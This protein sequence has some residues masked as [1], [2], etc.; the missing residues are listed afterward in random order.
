M[1]SLN[2]KHRRRLKMGQMAARW[3]S[4]CDAGR[5]LAAKEGGQCVKTWWSRYLVGSREAAAL[6]RRCNWA[7]SP[8]RCVVF[9]NYHKKILTSKIQKQIRTEYFYIC[10]R[11][12]QRHTC[13]RGVILSS[14]H[15]HESAA[16]A[17]AP[18][19]FR[20]RK[21]MKVA[22]GLSLSSAESSSSEVI[23]AATERFRNSDIFIP[24]RS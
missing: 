9:V 12:A 5:G 17:R 14:R 22:F 21:S 19:P 2:C 13:R 8:R 1:S 10:Y 23:P 6:S 15:R 24:T 7:R 3:A 16:F 11:A 20:T 4:F 18:C